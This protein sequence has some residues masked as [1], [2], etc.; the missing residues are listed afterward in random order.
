MN[1][2]CKTKNI[3]LPRFEM[4]EVGLGCRGGS[5]S[6]AESSVGSVDVPGIACLPRRGVLFIVFMLRLLSC[7]GSLSFFYR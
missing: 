3:V 4:V 6:R 7:D 2:F 5:I 1:L